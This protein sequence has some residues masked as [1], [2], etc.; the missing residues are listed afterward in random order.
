[1]ELMF[2]QHLGELARLVR[3]ISA[4]LGARPTQVHSPHLHVGSLGLR[5]SS[6]RS[7]L[8]KPICWTRRANAVSWQ[9]D[10]NR[11]RTGQAGS[12]TG[13]VGSPSTGAEGGGRPG[14]PASLSIDRES[15][16][17]DRQATVFSTA[18]GEEASGAGTSSAP[19]PGVWSGVPDAAPGPS[20]STG[21]PREL[22]PI[23]R[24]RRHPSSLSRRPRTTS[25]DACVTFSDDDLVWAWRGDGPQAGASLDSGGIWGFGGVQ[26]AAPG[27][28]A[29]GA[30][31]S[32]G[33]GGGGRRKVLPR[34]VPRSRK[35]LPSEAELAAEM[36]Q[37]PTADLGAA[38]C[39][40]IA[41]VQKVVESSRNLK[42]T[43]VRCLREAA[44][45]IKYAA[46]EQAKRTTGSEREVELERELRELRAGLAAAEAL[47]RVRGGGWRDRGWPPGRGC[48]YAASPAPGPIMLP[49]PGRHRRKARG[50]RRPPRVPYSDVI[51]RDVAGVQLAEVG[52]TD[53][54][55]RKG[56]TGSSILEVPGP[57]SAAKTD[58]LAARLAAVFRGTD[59]HVSRPGRT[60]EMRLTGLDESVTAAAVAAAVARVGGCAAAEVRSGEIRRNASGLGTAWVRCPIAA[61]G[62]LA[63]AGRVLVG[64]SSARVEALP[65][66]PLRCY[67]CLEE[68][69]VL[70]KRPRDADRGGRFY[71]C[72]GEGHMVRHYAAAPKCPVCVDLGRPADHRLSSKGCAPP[73]SRRGVARRR[74]QRRRS[75][76]GHS[77]VKTDGAAPPP[78]RRL[79]FKRPIGRR[80]ATEFQ[81]AQDHPGIS[82]ICD[83]TKEKIDS[84]GKSIE[85][86][87]TPTPTT[88]ASSDDPKP[89]GSKGPRVSELAERFLGDAD[90]P[91]QNRI[92]EEH[93]QNFIKQSHTV[94]PASVSPIKTT[95]PVSETT[96]G[97]GILASSTGSTSIS[98]KMS[99]LK[100]TSMD[101]FVAEG[102]VKKRPK[103][104]DTS[105]ARRPEGSV[106]SYAVD[107]LE[108]IHAL[109]PIEY[110]QTN[111]ECV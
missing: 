62:R 70:Q 38:I 109:S 86:A 74:R 108:I 77:V 43:Y 1:M 40:K 82:P 68:G 72:G 85:P 26:E 17:V 96:E 54:R 79:L 58:A 41:V 47:S 110:V 84:L 51:R 23:V 7:L 80:K 32:A 9:Q 91:S 104:A 88:S 48:C 42:G 106:D 50:G 31:A 103:M 57:E 100:L 105:P 76:C 90:A 53:L 63:T 39:E 56:Q 37:A 3:G 69:H 107:M 94:V 14:P 64:W 34:P 61:A 46:A 95:L 20:G 60:A 45:R 6:W 67:L 71:S 87:P 59:V 44:L 102:K 10:G 27:A 5:T 33:D 21:V 22:L 98:A 49:G 97:A 19:A 75:G 101:D 52:I 99:K 16:V 25:V 12:G 15:T 35:P 83:L 30:S 4:K 81:R 8:R 111:L 65:A 93:F 89:S 55:Y 73:S 24:L 78:G 92:E 18:T 28:H 2:H 29:P 11:C 13:G 66:R 36:R